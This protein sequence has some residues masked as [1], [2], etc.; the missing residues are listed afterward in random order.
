M[1]FTLT[2]ALFVSSTAFTGCSPKSSPPHAEPPATPKA[3]VH[4]AD[5]DKD[6]EFPD[7]TEFTQSKVGMV[8]NLMGAHTGFGDVIPVFWTLLEFR[9]KPEYEKL[10]IIAILD[11]YAYLGLKSTYGITDLNEFSKRMNISFISSRQAKVITQAKYILELF[12]AG[13]TA[14]FQKDHHFSGKKSIVVVSD[15]MHSEPLDHLTYK[16][17][18]LHF[19]PPGFGE[20]RNGI[21]ANPDC[22]SFV[23]KSLRQNKRIASRAFSR[24][25]MSSE[26]RGNIV[27]NILSKK[28]K[29]LTVKTSFLYGA[30]NTLGHYGAHLPDQTNS[31]LHALKKVSSPDNPVIV[32]TPNKAAHLEEV[33]QGKF[34]IWTLDE[35][36]SLTHLK[37]E[38]YLVSVG[39]IPNRQ[40]VS[41]IAS[42]DL[43]VIVEGNSAIST[44]ILLEK[45]FLIFRSQ[46]NYRQIKDI[47][48]L[49]KAK[50]Y[51]MHFEDAYPDNKEL[52]KFEKILTEYSTHKDRLTRAFKSDLPL[53]PQRLSLIL[54]LPYQIH[55]ADKAVDKK[56]EYE[57]ILHFI[58]TEIKDIT[59]E[60]SFILDA[61][62][63]GVISQS[64]ADAWKAE[65]TAK[66]VDL[67]SLEKRL[68]VK[69]RL[70]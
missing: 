18:M 55:K 20:K 26:F 53:F 13:R 57:S 50:S 1:T 15:N 14:A 70:Q 45:P 6:P 41:L 28:E 68:V 22:M 11:K 66:G 37:N 29:F 44:A 16:D 35:L 24:E 42:S 5:S 19:N 3:P 39:T 49:E 60:Y 27:Q 7:T 43:P 64:T 25:H 47:I 2:L 38:V 17:I 56:T 67:P 30:H 61:A 46:W 23:G 8:V 69:P 31:F 62:K 48:D 32:F 12:S 34:K 58:R 33:L 4:W 52:P 9:K 40:F 54:E 10:T 51:S 59:L 36:G 65:L 21:F 63:R